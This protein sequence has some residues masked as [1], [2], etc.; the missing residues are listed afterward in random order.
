MKPAL[1]AGRSSRQKTGAPALFNETSRARSEIGLLSQFG[2]CYVE[3]M[4]ELLVRPCFVGVALCA[5][6]LAAACGAG[7]PSDAMAV[8]GSAAS[9]SGGV[10]GS[11]P[12]AGG[13]VGGSGTGGAW[14]AGLAGGGT[15]GAA[16]GTA[17]AMAAAG[18]EPKANCMLGSGAAQVGQ[19]SLTD[20]NTC[21]TW[22]TARYAMP[23]S[24]KAAAKYCAGLEQDGISDWR[25]PRPEE[26]ATWAGLTEDSTAYVTGPIYVP[27]A[28]TSADGCLGNSHS[29]NLA[30][31]NSSSITCAW[32]GVGFQGWVECVSGTATPGTTNP[33][34]AG[35]NCSPC[36]AELATFSETDCSAFGE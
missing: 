27:K 26:L 10:S 20:G 14:A 28:G 4:H 35:A 7:S 33:A 3:L 1:Q 25:V 13:A 15:S 11:A 24:N 17:G 36:N 8:S 6:L 16:A 9:S 31:Y 34:Y 19:H 23:L 21:L 18:G 30:K 22:T 12:L 2:L 29:C 5:C 32:Q